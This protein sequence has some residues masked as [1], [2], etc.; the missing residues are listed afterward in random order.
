M[1]GALVGEVQLKQSSYVRRSSSW[2]HSCT[3]GSD[4]F[5]GPSPRAGG[6][7]EMRKARVAMMTSRR[8]AINATKSENIAAINSPVITLDSLTGKKVPV[9]KVAIVTQIS[10]AQMVPKVM[11]RFTKRARL[12]RRESS[13]NMGARFASSGSS[14]LASSTLARSTMRP[15][16]FAKTLS[17]VVTPEMRNTG[18]MDSWMTCAMAEI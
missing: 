5:A 4:A 3:K 6:L 18:A 11:A 2:R 1:M 14:S 13:S 16:R 8:N 17:K 12:E 15:S 7:E 10:R 9:N